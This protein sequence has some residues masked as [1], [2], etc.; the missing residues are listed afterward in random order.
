MD[1]SAKSLEK[2][3]KKNGKN[4]CL[5]FLPSKQGFSTSCLAVNERQKKALDRITSYF[6]ETGY[7]KQPISTSARAVLEKAINMV[8]LA[9]PKRQ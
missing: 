1:K 6:E 3:Q 7:G 4:G 8:S 9:V 5:I 2:W